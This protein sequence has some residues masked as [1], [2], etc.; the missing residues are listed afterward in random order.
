M[1]VRAISNRSHKIQARDYDLDLYSMHSQL[2]PK[3]VATVR[4]YVTALKRPGYFDE[5]SRLLAHRLA[6]NESPSLSHGDK[7]ACGGS[8]LVVPCVGER[9]HGSKVLCLSLHAG[10]RFWRSD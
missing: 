2:G 9:R 8:D 7:F 6:K 4:F 1:L 10:S 5:P 3:G